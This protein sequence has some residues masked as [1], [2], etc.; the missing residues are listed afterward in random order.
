VSFVY[1]EIWVNYLKSKAIRTLM[2]ESLL[3]N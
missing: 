1:A 3:S 2:H